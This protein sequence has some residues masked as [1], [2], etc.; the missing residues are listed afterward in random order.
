M[1]L[2]GVGSVTPVNASPIT[3]TETATGTGVLDGTHFTN[4]LVTITFFGDT[5][6]VMPF[7][8]TDLVNVPALSATVNVFGVG[9]DTFTD[10]VGI[11]GIP[12]PDPSLNNLAGVAFVDAAPMTSGLNILAT[13]TNALIGYD[14][15]SAIGPVSGSAV[16]QGVNTVYTTN[17]GSFQW[18]SAPA[19]ATFT[20][21]PRV[22]EPSTMV[23]LGT[24]LI[25]AAARRWRTRKV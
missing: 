17:A 18:T 3:Y 4:V 10:T 12:I 7:G 13:L 9:T 2:L 8:G 22:P 5:S 16:I 11:I 23:L 19:T 21:T 24:G 1:A 6:N 15:V 14:L 25:G 20:A